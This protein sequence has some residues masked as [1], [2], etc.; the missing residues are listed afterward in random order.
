VHTT[1]VLVKN[2][3]DVF[4]TPRFDVS[5]TC[6]ITKIPLS[7]LQEG[8]LVYIMVQ[9]QHVTTLATTTLPMCGMVGPLMMKDNDVLIWRACARSIP[10]N[11]NMFKELFLDVYHATTE[12]AVKKRGRETPLQ[13]RVESTLG[14]QHGS[15]DFFFQHFKGRGKISTRM[16]KKEFEVYVVEVYNSWV[17]W[18][19]DNKNH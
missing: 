9:Q 18:M 5:E 11:F 4:T 13:C 14:A 3:P 1:G 15:L 19:D 6:S 7:Q 2:G 17:L 8:M 12:L 16:K 10:K